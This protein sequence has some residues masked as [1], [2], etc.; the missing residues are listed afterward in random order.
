[1][2]IRKKLKII[3][4]YIDSNGCGYDDNDVLIDFEDMNQLE[5]IFSQQTEAERRCDWE[6]KNQTGMR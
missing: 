1:M 5:A 2:K 3:R 4:Y 6:A